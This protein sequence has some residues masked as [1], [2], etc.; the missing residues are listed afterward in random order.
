[1]NLHLEE[2]HHDAGESVIFLHG[3]NVAGW[4]WE[5]QVAALPDRHC[6][7]PDLPGLGGSAHRP[8][9][10]LATT[11]DEVAGIIRERAHG[12]RAHVVGLSL[13]GIV[14]ITLAARH[15]DVVRSAFVTGALLRGVHGPARWAGLAQLPFFGSAGYWKGLARAYGIPADS[16]D[17]FVR[18]GLGINRESA[19]RMIAEIHDG[20]PAGHLDGLRRLAAPVLTIAGEK[21]LRTF[22][23]SLDDVTARAPH[24]V[25]RVA[26]GMHHVWSVEDPELFRTTLAHWLH[27]GRPSP[28]LLP[29]Q[30]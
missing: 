29:L 2:H 25:A 11:A 12:G 30:T 15:P 17:L 1:M 7:V 23:G 13:G 24:A 9:T 22:R 5:D 21:E 6:L 10:D 14:G 3:G 19:R 4:M 26:P 27:T 28:A 20:G 16:T 18:T 8:W